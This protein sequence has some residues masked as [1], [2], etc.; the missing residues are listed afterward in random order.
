MNEPQEELIKQED[1]DVLVIMDACRSDEFHD[2]MY[3]HNGYVEDLEVRIS[4]VESFASDTPDFYGQLPE[5]IDVEKYDLFTANAVPFHHYNYKWGRA[6]LF[7][8]IKP[9]DNINSFKG[10]T[11]TTPAIIHFVPPHLPWQ[12]GKGREVIEDLGLD[13]EKFPYEIRDKSYEHVVYSRVEDSRCFYNENLHHGLM[14]IL[15]FIKQ[16]VESGFKVVLTSDHS[17]GVTE[18][19]GYCHLQGEVPWVTFKKAE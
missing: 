1:F 17:E 10:E 16:L 19:Q 12:Y 13:P 3:Y 11:W 9:E 8:S 5:Y 7:D 14:A 18:E 15:P 2:L 6:T 4:S